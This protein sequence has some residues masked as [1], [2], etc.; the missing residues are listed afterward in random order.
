MQDLVLVKVYVVVLVQ[1]GVQV[2][3]LVQEKVQVKRLLQGKWF[4]VQTHK[5]ALLLFFLYKVQLQGFLY[6]SPCSG[7]KS[8]VVPFSVSP[9]IS[10]FS[11]YFWKRMVFLL[12]AN[13]F[14]TWSAV[15]QVTWRRRTTPGR[16]GWQRTALRPSAEPNI[17]DTIRSVS[18]LRYA[19]C[20]YIVVERQLKFLAP[21]CTPVLY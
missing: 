10:L 21:Y 18:I 3:G 12:S 6:F 15:V 11:G 1:F 7:G 8:P 2:E 4:P 20:T 16:P 9:T 19:L 13:V 14:Q 17:L 5:N